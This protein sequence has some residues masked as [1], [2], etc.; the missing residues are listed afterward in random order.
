VAEDLRD[1]IEGA[2]LSRAFTMGLENVTNI[3]EA[4]H[5]ANTNTHSSAGAMS[6]VAQDGG[7]EGNHDEA[8]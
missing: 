7:G 1:F 5:E 3:G 6:R 8:G 2:S 4:R